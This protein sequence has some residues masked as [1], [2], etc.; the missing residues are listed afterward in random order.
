MSPDLEYLFQLG[1][2]RS[3]SHSVPGVV[4]LDLPLALLALGLAGLAA[5][6]LATLVPARWPEAAARLRTWRPPWSSPAA[7]VWLVIAIVIGALNH[8]VVDEF[9]HATGAGVELIPQF[10]GPVTVAG[11]TLPLYRWLQYGLSVGWLGV[12]A[13]VC[14]RWWRTIRPPVVSAGPP[15][16]WPKVAIGIAFVGITAMAAI[17]QAMTTVSSPGFDRTTAVM[18][19]I[20]AWRAGALMLVG[21]GAAARGLATLDL[22]RRW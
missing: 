11:R 5:P 12:L 18:L 4:L 19:V 14:V 16:E 1:T 10:D 13:V 3:I 2:A 7:A 21:L 8:V 9:T 22:D 15:L 6:G 20:G 17:A